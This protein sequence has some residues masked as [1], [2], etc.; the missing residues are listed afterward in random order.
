MD[1]RM[2]AVC[3]WVSTAGPALT[4]SWRVSRAAVF[5][6]RSTMAART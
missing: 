3:H 5:T 6:G 1:G 2:G 4:A